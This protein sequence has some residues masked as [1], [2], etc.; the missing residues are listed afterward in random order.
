MQ[1]AAGIAE[2]IKLIK[3]NQRRVHVLQKTLKGSNIKWLVVEW[4]LLGDTFDNIS[5]SFQKRVY[6]SN[7]RH[8]R[9]DTETFMTQASQ[10]LHRSRSGPASYDGN[11]FLV[12]KVDG[13]AQKSRYV[14]CFGWNDARLRSQVTDKLI[15]IQLLIIGI[16]LAKR[17]KLVEFIS[18]RMSEFES[19]FWCKESR[20]LT[21]Y[22]VRVAVESG[23]MVLVGQVPPT[24][25]CRPR[26]G[27]ESSLVD[28]RR[29][30]FSR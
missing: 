19:L 4:H 2:A 15:V 21:C 6:I 23:A 12:A 9:R 7:I 17:A 22:V 18:G 16:S 26:L 13:S 14:A 27:C 30:L 10:C 24:Y 1:D 3:S 29:M 25:D 28:H 20:K 8:Y 11:L 5:F